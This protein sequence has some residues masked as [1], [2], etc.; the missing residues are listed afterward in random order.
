MRNKSDKFTEWKKNNFN[1]KIPQKTEPIQHIGYG[2]I[3]KWTNIKKDELQ[4]I[5]KLHQYLFNMYNIADWVNPPEFFTTAVL[6]VLVLKEL[7]DKNTATRL[8]RITQ[9]RLGTFIDSHETI[10]QYLTSNIGQLVLMDVILKECNDYDNIQDIIDKLKEM[11]G[12]DKIALK[13]LNR[14]IQVPERL[15]SLVD[16]PLRDYN[17]CMFLQRISRIN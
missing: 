5:D 16:V 11:M 15:V 12:N 9:Q 17:T 14:E 2:F 6:I 4:K 1:T 7:I 10:F 3:M 8:N 13:I